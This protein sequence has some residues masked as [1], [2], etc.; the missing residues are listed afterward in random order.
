MKS[1]ASLSAAAAILAGSA[2]AFWRMPSHGRTALAR[3][4]PIVDKGVAS[5]HAHTIHGGNNFGASTTYEDL[6][7]S[8]CTSAQFEDDKSAYWTPTLHFVHENGKTEIVP[9]VGG[10]LAYYLLEGDNI[11]AFPKGFMMLA[12][13]PHQRNFTL[14][15]P[16]PPVYAWTDEDKTQRALAAKSIGMNCLNYARAPEGSRY[17]HTFPSKEFLDAECTDGIRAEMLFASCWN[18]KDLDTPDHKSH[19]AYPSM[20]DG[21]SCPDGFPVRLPTLFYETIWNT[22]AFKGQAGQ[23]VWSNGDPTGCG[24]HADFMNGWDI[25]TLQSAVDTC[26]NLSGRTEDCP[27]FAGRLQSEQKQDSCKVEKLPKFLDSDNCAGPANGLCGNNPIQYGPEYAKPN[28][29]SSGDKP[30]AKPTLSSASLP[31]LSYAP[32]RSMGAGGISVYNVADKPTPAAEYN[33]YPEIT[34]VA[35]PPKEAVKEEAPKDEKDDGI[36]STTTYT[37]DGVVY[38]VAIKEVEVYVTDPLRR[39]HAHAHRRNIGKH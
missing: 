14:P 13:D 18:G 20:L 29:P 34:P 7:N 28:P 36:V 26:T 4:D 8:E 16:D 33:S 31:T 3:L 2:D 23:F 15:V 6:R 9:Q 27:V 10:M 22:Y 24:Y 12:G 32:A 21:G 30:E 11:K 1:V 35:Q 25:D 39:R 5:S 38:V 19:V 37:K 17:R